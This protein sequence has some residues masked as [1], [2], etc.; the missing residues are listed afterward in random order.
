MLAQA[1]PPAQQQPYKYFGSQATA[2]IPHGA[3]NFTTHRMPMMPPRMPMPN[4]YSQF[5][6]YKQINVPPPNMA[7]PPPTVTD[8]NSQQMP[9][10]FFPSHMSLDLDA[11][12]QQ[13]KNQRRTVDYNASTI[14]HMKV[15]IS[16]LYF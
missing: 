6:Q 8:S 4:M 14:Q 16:S 12:R 13:R 1:I 3:A 15:P 9:P 10:P 2:S 5:N 7:V 11:R